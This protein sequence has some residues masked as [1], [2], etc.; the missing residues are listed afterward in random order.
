MP[1]AV[2]GVPAKARH[3]KVLSLA[4]GYRGAQSKLYRTAVEKVRRALRFAYRDRRVKKRD[5][6]GLWIVRIGSAA[7]ASGIS[8]SQLI[9][10]LKVA[11][12]DLNRKMLSE[13]AIADPTAF[14]QLVQ[15][16]RQ[17]LEKKAA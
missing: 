2:S 4:K 11:G 10:G 5:F 1:R 17:A 16:A 14:E 13:M 9:H 12:I 8:Y 7:K 6:R 15:Q 3:K